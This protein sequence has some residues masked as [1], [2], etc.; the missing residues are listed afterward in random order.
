MILK[1][2]L[3]PKNKEI[4]SYVLKNIV[5][6]QG[7]RNP[8]AQ[9]HACN[10]IHLLNDGLRELR[11]AVAEK[12]LPYYMIP[13]RNLMEAC[14]LKDVLQRKWVADITDMLEEGPGVILRLKTI[15][16]AIV[17]SPEPMLWFS[18][19]RMEIEMLQLQ[20]NIR[21]V[22]CMDENLVVDYS[23]FIMNA[24]CRRRQEI[25]MEMRQILLLDGSSVNDENDIHTELLK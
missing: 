8:Q 17:A 11:T 21:R 9:L 10:L 7:E 22:Q 1:D 25:L 12:H 16:K 18:K 19:K 4:T 14:G 13:K 2:I 5:L 24:T 15:R 6:W 20:E 3:K 23:D